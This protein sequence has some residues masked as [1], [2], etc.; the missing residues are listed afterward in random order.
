MSSGHCDWK[1]LYLGNPLGDVCA[2]D[3]G[4]VEADTR[5]AFAALKMCTR[6]LF[7]INFII[8]RPFK[9]K[10]NNH[11][12]VSLAGEGGEE[13]W[14]PTPPCFFKARVNISFI[15]FYSPYNSEQ[16]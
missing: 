8:F 10:H 9:S 4:R 12:C 7:V 2:F 5:F 13:N 3:R 15:T 14:Q 1:T 16:S 11:V 6:D